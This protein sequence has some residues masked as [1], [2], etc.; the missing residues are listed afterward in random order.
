MAGSGVV[1]SS[2]I[3]ACEANCGAAGPGCKAVIYYCERKLL[4]GIDV[5]EKAQKVSKTTNALDIHRFPPPPP[6][7]TSKTF[8]WR[9][10]RTDFKQ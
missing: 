5:S 8:L 10:A 9:Y 2:G 6:L 1:R 7:K 4:G 3:V